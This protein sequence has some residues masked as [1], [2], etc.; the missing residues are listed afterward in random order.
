MKKIALFLIALSVTVMSYAQDSIPSLLDYIDEYLAQWS[1]II[2]SEQNVNT[3]FLKREVEPFCERALEED[4]I[5]VLYFK[6]RIA[7]SYDL[8]KDIDRMVITKTDVY[9]LFKRF[10]PMLHSKHNE[11][12]RHFSDDVDSISV[13]GTADI[14][15]EDI[16]YSIIGIKGYEMWL[17]MYIG[18]YAEHYI[19][20][21]I[22]TRYAIDYLKRAKKSK[23]E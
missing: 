22:R 23:T 2:Q 16:E 5:A 7:P 19:V 8:C 1:D 17:M 9:S 3:M 13:L 11:V 6:E 10:D 15:C 4:A 18:K 20:D 12:W 21:E 14:K